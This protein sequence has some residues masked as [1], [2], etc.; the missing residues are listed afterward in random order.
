MGKTGVSPK[1]TA[2]TAAGALATIIVYVV[3]L[4]GVEVPAE[5]AAAL[6]TL[7]AVVAAYVKGDPLR[8]PETDYDVPAG[9]GAHRADEAE[10]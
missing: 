6:A 5:V 3:S 1:V 9:D 4:F 10:V 7:I 8:V 2:A